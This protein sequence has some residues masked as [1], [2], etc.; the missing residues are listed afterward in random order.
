[1]LS[2][3]IF[4]VLVV[5]IGMLFLL[6]TNISLQRRMR[7]TEQVNRQL[8]EYQQAQLNQ[9]QQL[10]HDLRGPMT[11]AK[12]YLDLLM[13]NRLKSDADR[14]KCLVNAKGS[15]EKLQDIVV[16]KLEKPITEMEQRLPFR[17]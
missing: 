2:A 8:V 16:V 6:W 1:M 12:G 3:I 11:A 15:V 10:S 7:D 9:L 5:T 13:E 17:S 14:Q 4:L